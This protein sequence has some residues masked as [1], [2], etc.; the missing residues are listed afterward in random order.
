[1]KNKFKN[2][3]M[4]YLKKIIRDQPEDSEARLFAQ[5]ELERRQFWKGNIISWIALAISFASLI[6]SAYKIF[7]H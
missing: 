2:L 3:P 4:E 5:L 6:L 1:M 7:F